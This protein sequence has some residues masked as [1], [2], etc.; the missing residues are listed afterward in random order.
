[1]KKVLA[2][3]GT[4]V[5]DMIDSEEEK[6]GRGILFVEVKE[7][8]I[9]AFHL[10]KE[11][12]EGD[13]EMQGYVKKVSDKQFALVFKNHAGKQEIAFLERRKKIIAEGK[14]EKKDKPK[15]KQVKKAKSPAPKPLAAP[16]P[17]PKP[18]P[19]APPKPKPVPAAPKPAHRLSRH[20]TRRTPSNARGKL[21]RTRY[22]RRGNPGSL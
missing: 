15:A 21:V 7:G 10:P 22:T 8:K 4:K 17:T 9:S 12:F 3:L 18:K 1:M 6:H 2:S 19:V 16:K 20:E 5:H 13:A 14:D 11:K